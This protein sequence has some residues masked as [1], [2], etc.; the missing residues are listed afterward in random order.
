MEKVRSIVAL[1]GV[2]AVLLGG[3]LEHEQAG[4]LGIDLDGDGRRDPI[5]EGVG[6]PWFSCEEALAHASAGDVCDLEGWLCA[7]AVDDAW[8]AFRSVTCVDHRIVRGYETPSEEPLTSCEVPP[9]ANGSCVSI[10]AWRTQVV[11]L[12]YGETCEN[13]PGRMISICVDDAVTP[14]VPGPDVPWTLVDS[15]SCAD[16]IAGNAQRGDACEGDFVC[17]L[18][19]EPVGT[20]LCGPSCPEALFQGIVWCGD[21]MIR[22]ARPLS[23]L[24]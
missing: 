6:G 15:S 10:P 1:T 4:S 20:W 24:Q 11:S 12:D 17:E 23:L 5:P 2:V 14:R 16:L 9:S 3:C 13:G 22:L 19:H 21:G 18:A 8:S 7:E